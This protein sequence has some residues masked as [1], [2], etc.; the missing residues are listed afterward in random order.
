MCLVSIMIWQSS[1]LRCIQKDMVEM[2]DKT[3][4]NV[5]YG[6]TL[7]VCVASKA[8]E[9]S[10]WESKQNFLVKNINKW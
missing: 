4:M 3:L 6:A 9:G 5:N 7:E 10:W 1:W 2:C 8:S